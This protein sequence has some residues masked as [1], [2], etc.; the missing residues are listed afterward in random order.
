MHKILLLFSVLVFTEVNCQ[1]LNE[2]VISFWDAIERKD[3]KKIIFHGLNVIDSASYYNTYDSSIIEVRLYTALSFSNIGEYEKALNINQKTL[4]LILKNWSDNKMYYTI[5]S[6]NIATIYSRLGEYS[7]AIISLMNILSQF[8]TDEKENII[9]ATCLNNISVLYLQTQD[10]DSSIIYGKESLQLREKL[11]GKGNVGYVQSLNN[12]A[13]AYSKM[14]EYSLSMEYLL[15]AIKI[16]DSIK[17]PDLALKAK[18][19]NNI[20]YIY[21]KM[22]NYQLAFQFHVDALELRNKLFGNHHPDYLESMVNIA[23]L[24]SYY[25]NDS[26]ALEFNLEILELKKDF[27]SKNSEEYLKT[28]STISSNYLALKNFNKAI[29]YNKLA[30]KGLKRHYG[31]LNLS[32]LNS[33]NTLGIIYLNIG[34]GERSIKI[35]EQILKLSDS[36][37]LPDIDFYES[38]LQNLSFVYLKNSNYPKSLDYL[39]QSY[40]SRYKN[41]VSLN[42]GFDKETLL[43]NKLSLEEIFFLEANINHKFYP[44]NSDS[45]YHSWL[46][47]NG[48]LSWNN[49]LI[50]DYKNN[51][52]APNEIELLNDLR[53]KQKSL[54]EYKQRSI[55]DQ[56]K[57]EKQ[58]KELVFEINSAESQ[59][60]TRISDFVKHHQINSLQLKKALQENELFIDIVPYP[61]YDLSTNRWTDTIRYMIFFVNPDSSSIELLKT[62]DVIDSEFLIEGYFDHIKNV[63]I[64]NNQNYRIYYDFWKPIAS[65]LGDA[66]TIYVSLGGAYN[67]INLNTIFNPE[68]GKYLIEE[69]DIRIVNS[70]RDFVLSKSMVKREYSSNT[71]CLFG[72]PNFE[73]NSSNPGEINDV[74]SNNTDLNIFWIDSLTRGGIIANSLPETK[75]EIQ[76]ISNTISSKDWNVTS[77]LGDSADEANIKKLKSPRVLH[78]ATHG[79]FFADI[80]LSTQNRF[81]GMNPDQVIQD[82]M[83]RSGLLLTGANKTLNGEISKGE[84]GLLSAAEASLLDLRETELVVLSACETGKGEETNSEGVYG[85][86]K[87]FA[88]AGAQNIIMS[89]WKV[90]DKV[91]KEFMSRFY[92]IWLN[93]KMTIREAFNRTQL[94]IKAN[95]PEPYYWGAFILVGE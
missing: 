14:G 8:N 92:E 53:T 39:S 50:L 48:L 37:L 20:G 41:F 83:L 16:L 3:D 17:S 33:L 44:F 63:N 22:G 81:L 26:L 56:V 79:Y 91:T 55:S 23:V 68:T 28:L 90:D 57:F 88:D 87:A 7:N 84:N 69:Y 65:K 74:F 35:F 45:L 64:E 78:I 25:G 4:D 12:I 82:P 85:L 54:V 21:Q 24:L 93:E 42:L 60:N 40:T 11:N 29:K 59:I 67:K 38:V 13:S 66:K 77:Y 18:L 36:K 51:F 76:N 86:R 70:A 2:S 73:G 47:L 89:L 32:Y 58:I 61:E 49:N 75:L 95:Y 6:N 62:D 94:E 30:S 80:P 10:F 31:H 71:A 34:K 72:F 43:K 1:S 15:T 19:Q 46:N 5:C 52:F 27:Y 9:Y